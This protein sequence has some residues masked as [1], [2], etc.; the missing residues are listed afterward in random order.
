MPTNVD[1]QSMIFAFSESGS[2][3]V[4]SRVDSLAASTNTG[5]LAVYYAVLTTHTNVFSK[6]LHTSSGAIQVRSSYPETGWGF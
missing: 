4:T 2:L 5:L 1:R 3:R 6:Q